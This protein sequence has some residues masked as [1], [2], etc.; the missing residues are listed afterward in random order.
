MKCLTTF[1]KECSEQTLGM[2][3]EYMAVFLDGVLVGDPDYIDC[4]DDV[5]REIGYKYAIE[6]KLF[7]KV[8]IEAMRGIIMEE[9]D[10]ARER[11]NG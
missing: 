10:N 4:C 7:D 3:R 5:V 6:S 8:T 2:T 9:I 11:A 1:T